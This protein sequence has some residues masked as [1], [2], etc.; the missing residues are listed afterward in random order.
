MPSGC[1]RIA[2]WFGEKKKKKKLPHTGIGN[3]MI[4][5]YNE[6]NITQDY[7]NN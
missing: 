6:E 7:K 2:H 1:S 4:S 3:G 5:H